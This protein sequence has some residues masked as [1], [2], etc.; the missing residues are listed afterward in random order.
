VKENVSGRK[1]NGNLSENIAFIYKF[2]WAVIRP[3]S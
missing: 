2:N 3:W 1:E